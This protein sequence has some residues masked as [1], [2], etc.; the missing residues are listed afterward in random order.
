MSRP[1]VI[2]PTESVDIPSTSTAPPPKKKYWKARIKG[3]IKKLLCHQ[4]DI[5]HKLDYCVQ[6]AGQYTRISYVPPKENNEEEE[7]VGEEG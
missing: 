1:P 5:N 2:S 7:L 3:Y 4:L 6:A